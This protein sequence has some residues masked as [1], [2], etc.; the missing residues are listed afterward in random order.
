MK[1]N[2]TSSHIEIQGEL[3]Q[4]SFGIKQSP[5]AF[6]ILS[7]G[8]YSNKP[9]AIVRELSAN[10]ADAHVL[11]GNQ[12]VPFEIKL[13]NR[14]DSQFYLKDFGPGLSHDQVMRLYTT[15]FDSTK[16]ESND[17]IGGLGLGSKSP[18]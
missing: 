9:M 1:L 2:T 11:N 16:S 8:L 4:G 6:Q 12:A 14:L 15:Y 18:F 10:A 7:S 17:F 5:K 3:E 13:P